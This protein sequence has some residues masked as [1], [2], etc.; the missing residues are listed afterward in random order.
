MV[1]KLFPQYPPFIN[2]KKETKYLTDY[3]SSAPTSMLFVYGPK[4][5]GKTTLITRVY[6]SLPQDEY[7]ISYL[8]MRW[9]LIKDFSD[10]QNVFFPLDRKGKIK[11]IVSGIQLNMGFFGWSI[12]DEKMMQTNLF[13]VMENKLR[14]AQKN[15]I[16]PVIIIDEFQYLKHIIID[17]EHNLLLVEEL[18]KF[19]IRLTKVLH[20]AH[21]V[22]LTSDSYYIEELYAHT[23]LKNTSEFFLVDHISYDDVAYR[24][25]QTESLS[26]DI[27]QYFWDHLWWSVREIRQ[28]LIKYKNTGDYITPIQTMI[29]DEYG[30]I[31]DFVMYK[32][33]SKEKK[34][35]FMVIQDIILNWSYTIAINK[36]VSLLLIK[37]L[38]DMDVWFYD[39]RHLRITANSQS[40]RKAFERL[41][42]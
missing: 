11:E 15:W 6:E 3:F 8:D 40:V 31:G 5:T 38:V 2:R 1:K 23:K 32:L 14:Q 25:G 37:K 41:F 30:K 34:D 17:K 26:A 39:V 9:V 42:E 7:A 24:L 13:A 27:V 20:L 35:F 10:F 12:D 36:P 18:W 21:V 29:S 16:K 19:F 22:C 33:E 4:S 28:A